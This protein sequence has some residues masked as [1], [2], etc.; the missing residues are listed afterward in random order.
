MD[1]KP[2]SIEWS[3]KRY[4]SEA[5]QQ[6]FDDN[7]SVDVV[8]ND[9][10]DVLLENTSYHRERAEKFEQLMVELEKLNGI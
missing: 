5:I 1:Y 6:Y 3:R 7:V 2:Y 4:L 10:V 9:I 8:L